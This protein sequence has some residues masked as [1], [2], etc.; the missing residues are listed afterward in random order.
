MDPHTELQPK[1]TSHFLLMWITAASVVGFFLALW[2]LAWVFFLRAPADFPAKA[3]FSVEKGQSLTVLAERLEEAKLIRS[4]SMF[5][6]FAVVLGKQRTLGAGEYYFEKPLSAWAV[7]NRISQSA[8]GIDYVQVT[9]PEGSSVTQMAALI[10]KALPYF[11]SAAF[12]KIAK[13]NEGYLFPDT[14]R[15][16]P[17]MTAQDI[18][19]L[20][21][22]NF[23]KRSES[24]Q[25]LLKDSGKLLSDVVKMASIVEEEGRTTETRRSIAGI[26]WKRLS[27]SMPLQVDSSFLYINGKTSDKLT[28][29]DLA[30]DSPYN[31]YTRKGLPPTPITNPGLDSLIATLTPIK[32]PYLYFLTDTKGVMHYART[33]DEHV[34][35]KARYLK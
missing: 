18:A 3:Y 28:L 35:N 9:F 7:V 12:I 11:D 20:M 31:S 29:E 26:L 34:A 15:L 5:R 19:E 6:R 16:L 13:P 8:Y 27:V 33:F 24:F 2:C 17:S 4:A 25:T 21:R 10:K 22:A 23:V 1:P 30:I 14:Y 32:T